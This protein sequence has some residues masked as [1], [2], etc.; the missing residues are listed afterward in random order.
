MRKDKKDV[1][2][3]YVLLKGNTKFK[4]SELGKGR[5]LTASRIRQTWEKLHSGNEQ[6]VRPATKQPVVPTPKPS[7]LNGT[8]HRSQPFVQHRNPIFEDYTTYKP[9]HQPTEFEYDG[10]TYKRYLPD[11]VLDFFNYEFDYLELA[12][13]QALQNLA[14]AY[15]TLIASPYEVTSGGGG[16]G[17]GASSNPGSPA[18]TRYRENENIMLASDSREKLEPL[19]DSLRQDCMAGKI[20]GSIRG[21][22]TIRTGFFGSSV[23]I[24]TAYTFEGGTVWDDFEI[25]MGARL[26][27]ITL[28]EELFHTHQCSGKTPEEY[29]GMRLNNEIEAK[30]CWYMYRLKIGNMNG[31]SKYISEGEGRRIFGTLSK[32]IMAGNIKSDNFREEYRNAASL[33][34]SMSRSYADV[35][36]YPLSEDAVNV[37]VLMKMMEDCPEYKNE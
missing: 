13:W 19:L 32:Y 36:L 3:G 17:G 28:L 10:E 34:R 8:E 24:P 22:V 5:N 15:F 23:M 37:D 29:R 26:D 25:R 2:R 6:Q 18:N 1:I 21:N 35:T 16:G 7:V 12:N 27:D 11:K 14:M 33:L 20:I 4:A 30:L 9:N 31:V